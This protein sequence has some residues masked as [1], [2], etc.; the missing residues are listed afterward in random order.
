MLWQPATL[1]KGG[2]GFVPLFFL[3][4]CLKTKA[5]L[6]MEV[7]NSDQ[8]KTLESIFLSKFCDA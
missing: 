6:K 1:I 4:D 7:V 8:P 2:T 5:N 3:T